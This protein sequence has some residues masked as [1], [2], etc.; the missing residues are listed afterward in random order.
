MIVFAVSLAPW[1]VAAMDAGRGALRRRSFF[2][3]LLSIREPS[4]A[5]EDA[6]FI[7]NYRAGVANVRIVFTGTSKKN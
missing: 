2:S 3:F 5:A 7:I 1:M 6:Q 4:A